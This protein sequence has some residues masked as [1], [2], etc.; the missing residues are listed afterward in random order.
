MKTGY[1]FAVAVPV[2]FVLIQLVGPE[3]TN[4]PVVSSRAME[5]HLRMD[6]KVDEILKRACQNC[7]SH[8]TRWP[9]Y[10]NVAPVSWFVIDNVNWGRRHMNFSDWAQYDREEAI[11]LLQEMCETTQAQEMPLLPY[12]WMHEEA[13]VRQEEID[14]LCQWSRQEQQHLR[15]DGRE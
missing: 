12:I 9:W 3:K 10:S 8:Q 5:K 1:W 7:H 6:P 14:L 2:F 4:P 11:Q 13:K 15:K